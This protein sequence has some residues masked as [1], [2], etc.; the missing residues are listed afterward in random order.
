[1]KR[2]KN[3]FHETVNK[4]LKFLIYLPNKIPT[5]NGS[6]K[7]L[8]LSWY[9]IQQVKFRGI[10]VGVILLKIILKSGIQYEFFNCQS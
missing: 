4:C 6:Q 7:Y 2:S 10:I 9:F 5:K 8:F 3:L 1:M